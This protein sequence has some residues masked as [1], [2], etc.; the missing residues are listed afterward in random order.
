M[1]TVS[2]DIKISCHNSVIKGSGA[3]SNDGH[4]WRNWKITVVAMDGEKEVKGK[5]SIILDHICY[6]L[7]PTFPEPRRDIREEPYVLEEKGWGEFDM[8]IVLYFTDNLTDPRVI[9]F[10]LNFAQSNYSITHKLEFPNA[11]PELIRLLA[12][13]PSTN[14]RKGGKKPISLTNNNNK[15]KPKKI[16][17]ETN[18]NDN[19]NNESGNSSR[20]SSRSRSSSSS[21]RQTAK[22]KPETHTKTA[23][24]AKPETKSKPEKHPKKTYSPSPIPRS[25]SFNN[26]SP[27]PNSISTSSPAYSHITTATPESNNDEKIVSPE[28][29]LIQDEGEH[30]YT[31]RD[32]YNLDSIH[33]AKIDE[34]TRE[35]W[36]IPEINMME[37][38]KRIYRMPEEQ[39]EELQQIIIDNQTDDMQMIS[40][41]DGGV[42]IDLYSLGPSL[43]EKIWDFSADMISDDNQSFTSQDAHASDLELDSDMEQ[44]EYNSDDDGEIRTTYDDPQITDD[45]VHTEREE[46]EESDYNRYGSGAYEPTGYREIG[47]FHYTPDHNN[48]IQNSGADEPSFH[49]SDNESTN[50]EQLTSNH[51]TNGYMNN[52]MTNGGYHETSDMD[53]QDDDDY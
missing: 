18:N 22:K 34:E 20:S 52:H 30:A 26:L 40:D 44:G 21:G 4:P 12:K 51:L 31:L 42:G 37:L 35:R 17:T 10:D 33:R 7:H 41:P 43:L 28:N 47:E 19:N 29:N 3:K 8:R 1:T 45:D 16:N 6:I 49:F 38:A 5:L 23:K 14:A 2:Q 36:G 15:S 50:G 24:K 13:D 9:T 39:C 53:V 46:G 25:P 32:V 11:S 27:A 48:I